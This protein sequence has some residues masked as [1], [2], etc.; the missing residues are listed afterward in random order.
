M[1]YN[2]LMFK[3]LILFLLTG[4][5]TKAT[6][7]NNA[8]RVCGKWVSSN[9]N[10]IVLVYREGNT[11]KGKMVW[12]KNTDTS[13]AMDEWTD[14]HNPDPALRNRKILGLNILKEMTYSPGS[15]SWQNGKI[16]DIS[17]GHEYSASAR[18]G[19]DGVLKV[20][21]YWHFKFIG[22]TMT[23]VRYKD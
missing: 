21:G 7:A 17:S 2:Q 19:K 11:F 20:T 16:Y 8:D 23:F 1:L 6:Q 5:T 9:K 12:Y 15:D 10:I 4:F 13:K 22:R 14:K 18:L 3:F